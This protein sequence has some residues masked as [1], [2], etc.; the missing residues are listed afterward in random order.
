MANKTLFASS[1]NL[2]AP[3]NTV[4]EAGGLAYSQSDKEALAQL[5]VTC[6]L[7]NVFYASAEESLTKV[8]ELAQ[9]VDSKFLAKLALYSRHRGHMKD[10]PALF[11]AVLMGRGENELLGEVFPQVINNSKML[12]NFVQI[13]RSGTVGRK[14]FGSFTK[15]LIQNWLNGRELDQLFDDSIGHANPS[16]ADI[17]KM[18]HP[19]PKSKK[20]SNLYSYLLGKKFSLASLPKKVADF[21]RFKKDQTKKVPDVP[22][23]ALTALPLTEDHWAEVARNAGWTMTRMNLNTF[24]RHGVFKNKEL[25]KLVANRLTDKDQ[26][27]KSKCFPYQLMTAFLNV[28]VNVPSEISLALQNAME[29]AIENVPSLDKKVC[30]C[31][32]TSGSM[33][34]PVTGH[35]LGSTSVVSC[36][37]VAGLFAS[38]ILRKNPNAEILPF[39]TAVHRVD[40]NPLDSVMTNAKKLA[41]NGGGTDCSCAL[42]KLNEEGWKGDL[43]VYFSDNQSWLLDCGYV[44][45]GGTS[46]ATEWQRFKARNP[47][48]KLVL[49]DVQPYTTTTVQTDK[50]VLNIGGWSDTVFE[51]LERFVKGEST[52]FVK[53]VEAEGSN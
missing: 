25:V 13:V 27:R 20:Q 32:D 8:L 52:N 2:V 43:V 10:M 6:C 48:A 9:R 16:L 21:E 3:A 40:L 50:D 39:D 53:V 33:S 26:V 11:C 29:I 47:K 42:R 17:I 37:Q 49:I 51:V 30:V 18:V 24:G 23:R 46:T 12:C 4:N 41:L 19:N 34:S 28:D 45:G 22:F 36:V 31:V 44:Y 1:R 35:R 7:N 14:S 38:V 15:R 5:A